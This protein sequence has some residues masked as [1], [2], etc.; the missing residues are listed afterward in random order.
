MLV[1]TAI[2][3][4]PEAVADLVGDGDNKVDVGQR[5]AVVV[6]RRHPSVPQLAHVGV[7]RAAGV[8]HLMAYPRGKRHPEVLKVVK[9]QQVVDTDLL[10]LR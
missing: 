1:A 10:G 2:V 3:L 7:I 4:G 6:P 8:H 5:R 9:R